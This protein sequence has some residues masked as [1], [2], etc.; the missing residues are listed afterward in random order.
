MDRHPQPSVPEPRPGPRKGRSLYPWLSE[1]MWPYARVISSREAWIGV[2]LTA[3]EAAR[4]GMT[5]VV[6]DHYASAD[7]ET[8]S[9]VARTVEEVG[10]RGAVTRACQDRATRRHRSGGPR[11]GPPSTAQPGYLHAC[12]CSPWL[13]CGDD[14]HG[15]GSDLRN[16]ASTKVAEAELIAA[17]RAHST[18]LI[19]RAGLAVPTAQTMPVAPG[20]ST[21]FPS[22][23]SRSLRLPRCSG[24]SRSRTKG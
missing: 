22:S 8:T 23:G 13:G 12:L 4:A 14:D 6:E 1:F 15:R 10:L 17:V 7:L 24:R 3:L 16:G 9:G 18:E 21:A 19:E 11:A 5:A 20:R 2:R